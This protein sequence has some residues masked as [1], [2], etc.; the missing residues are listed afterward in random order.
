V[1]NPDLVALGVKF[2]TIQEFLETE[3]KPRFG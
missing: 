3:V 1:P 2:G